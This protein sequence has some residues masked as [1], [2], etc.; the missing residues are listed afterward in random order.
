MKNISLFLSAFIFLSISSCKKDDPIA[1]IKNPE[2]CTETNPQ[3]LNLEVEMVFN[4][5][6]FEED[7]S[8]QLNDTTYVSFTEAYIYF[9]NI[10]LQSDN[11]ISKTTNDVILLNKGN[12]SFQLGLMDIN[13]YSGIKISFG[14]DSLR[15][16]ADPTQYPAKHPLGLQ[17]PSMHWS[18]NQGY[19]FALL[20]GN[21][22]NNPIDASNPGQPWTYHIGLDGNYQESGILPINFKVEGCEENTLMLK[23][24]M[25]KVFEGVDVYTENATLTSNFFELS[26]RIGNNLINS[27]SHE[28]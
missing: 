4:D 28:N 2:S 11:Q 14:I 9:S 24:N 21:Y 19:I 18:W 8:F 12:Q 22:S 27:I 17:N 26:N 6:I 3:M 16:H 23:V 25:A 15:N 7:Q 20:E 5:L 10:S 1:P 13:D